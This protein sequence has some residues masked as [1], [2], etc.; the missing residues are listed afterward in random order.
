MRLQV[1]VRMILVFFGVSLLP[2]SAVSQLQTASKCI[3]QN[4]SESTSKPQQACQD[5]TETEVT[6]LPLRITRTKFKPEETLV[7]IYPKDVPEA[8]WRYD[9]LMEF[10]AEFISVIPK[11]VPILWVV[12]TPAAQAELEDLSAGKNW[13]Y[14]QCP[15]IQDIWLGDWLPFQSRDTNDKFV[16]VQFYYSESI[17]DE[18]C[19]LAVYEHLGRSVKK[20]PLYLDGGNFEINGTDF[21]IMTTSIFEHNKNF[22]EDEIT[23]MLKTYIDVEDV[24]YFDS[25][26][27]LGHT[28]VNLR[29]AKKDVFL[30]STFKNKEGTEISNESLLELIEEIKTKYPNVSFHAIPNEKSELINEWGV[31][32]YTGNIMDFLIAGDSIVFPIFTERSRQALKVL[33]SALADEIKI[34]PFESKNLSNLYFRGGGLYCIT[35]GLSN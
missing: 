3:D 8:E 34:I 35:G 7:L 15:D 23:M 14:L 11:Q 27:V 1:L 26:S 21:I 5:T 10:Y 2:V 17:E 33:R 16:G 25:S 19:G 30:Y 28:D 12:K 4:S 22:S 18:E 32:D 31:D 9:E 13:D 29:L 6:G 24:F 20:I